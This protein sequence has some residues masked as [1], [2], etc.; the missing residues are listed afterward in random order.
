MVGLTLNVHTNSPLAYLTITARRL[1]AW[2]YRYEAHLRGLKKLAHA[3][4]LC[5]ISRT[6]LW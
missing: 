3:G 2:G 1:E 6:I 4:G 5:L